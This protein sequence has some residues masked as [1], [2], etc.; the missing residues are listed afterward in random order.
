MVSRTQCIKAYI[1]SEWLT[2]PQ[3]LHSTVSATVEP[4][5]AQLDSFVIQY[6]CL[7]LSLRIF[8]PGIVSSGNAYGNGVPSYFDSGNGVPRNSIR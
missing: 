3:K 6:A 7:F 1:R 2:C 4:G 5:Q 8:K